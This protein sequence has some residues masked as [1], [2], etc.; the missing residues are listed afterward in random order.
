MPKPCGASP[1]GFTLIEVMMAA[2][3]L[4]VGFI[5]LIQVVTIGSATRD[6][7]R[8]QQIAVQIMEGEI[9]RLRT[10]S[11]ASI[12]A[13]IASGSITINANGAVSGNEELFALTNYTAGNTSD[14]NTELAAL[15]KGFTCS[16]TRT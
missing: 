12:A 2:A 8:K 11:W 5:G 1:A 10:G 9:E 15:A 3:I 14:D 4:V 7:A 16:Y 13:L 6:T